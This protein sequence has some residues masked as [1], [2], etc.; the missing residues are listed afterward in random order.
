MLRS[1]RIPLIE[2]KKI[3]VSG[4]LRLKVSKIQSLREDIDPILPTFNFMFL[5]DIDPIIKILTQY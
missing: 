3:L 4:F 5:E 1:R 2:N